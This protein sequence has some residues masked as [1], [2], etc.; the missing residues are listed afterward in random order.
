MSS[1]APLVLLTGFEPFGGMAHNPSWDVA[2][3]VAERAAGSLDPTGPASP[4]GPTDVPGLEVRALRLPV[5]FGRAAGLLADAVDAA[6]AEGRTPAAVVALGLA[7]GTEAVRLERV[8]LNLRDAR[9][10]DNDGAQPADEPVVASGEG[11]LFST[12]RLKAALARI[13]EAGIPV[14]LSLSAGSFVCN[15]V[16][17]ALLHD[18]SARGLDVPGGFV[19]VPD[20][21]DPQSPVSLAQAVEA[22]ELLLAETLRGGADSSV[23]GGALH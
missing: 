21:R 23:P 15:D 1:A 13:R 10:P 18:L 12:L 4:T 16:L 14:H 20:L 2:T 17:Y 6:V 11:A 7:A 9:I 8:G 22:V 3:A 5:A 19:H